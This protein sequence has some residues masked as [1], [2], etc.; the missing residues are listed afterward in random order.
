MD[1]FDLT[2]RTPEENLALDEALLD[3]AEEAARPR[4]ALR[5]WEAGEPFV[6]VG[7]NSQ[8]A[9]EVRLAACRERNIPV[10]RRTSGGSAIVAA[11]GCLMYAVVL[12]YELRP[13]LRPLDLAHRFV[14]GTMLEA[15]R[16]FVP[17]ATRQ[18]TS[19]LTLSGVKFSGNSLRCRRRNF[20]YHGTLLYDFPLALVERCLA[21]PPREPDYRRSRPHHAFLANLPAAVGDLRQ[22]M[23]GIW[24]AEPTNRDWPRLR[25]QDLVVTRYTQ[26]DWNFR[27]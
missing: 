23:I 11:R 20:L 9:E 2:L 7:R 6:V 24:R 19:D 22:A 25:V 18:G 4:E 14:L 17:A 10:L 21:M 27:R 15:L 8:V 1:L 13:E 12:N 5:L 16:P 3:E 26:A